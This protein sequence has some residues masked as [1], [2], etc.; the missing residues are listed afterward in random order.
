MPPATL[1]PA[2]VSPVRLEDRYLLAEGEVFLSGV[3]ALVR[4]LL[5]QHVADADAGRRTGIFASGYQGSPLG[6]FDRELA[7]LG[8]LAQRHDLVHRPGVNEE[9]GATAVWG[10]QLVGTL[11]NPL[12]DGVLGVWYGKA[13]GVDRATDAMRH[14]NYVGTDPRGGV[15]ALCGDDPES[16]S[17]TLP[18]ASEPLLAALHIPV[19]VPGSVQEVLDLGRHAIACS[20]A[21][22]LWTA[23]KIITVVADGAATAAVGA[24]RV[25]PVVPQLNW[26]GKPY[27]HQPSGHLLPPNSLEMERTLHGVRLEL[28]RRYARVNGLNRILADPPTARLGV[29][30]AGASYYDL[31]EAISHLGVGDRLRILK[32]GMVYPLDRE[33]VRDFAGGLD[34]I[35]VLEQKGPF[36]EPLVKDALY[37]SSHTP[38]VTGESDDRGRPLLATTGVLS[39]DAIARAIG[40]RLLV[41]EDLPFVQARLDQIDATARRPSVDVGQTRTPHF[42]SG[43]PH[44]ASTRAPEDS[45][46]GAGIGCHTM[47]MLTTAGRGHVVGTTQMGGEGAQWIGAAPF[48]APRH[49]LQN[50]GDGTFHHS[51]S[52]AIRA[53]IAAGVNVTYKILYNET[54]AMTGGQ[55]PTGQM[56][57]A[58]MARSLEAEGVKRIIIT[59][60]DVRRY[61]GVRLPALA[62]VRDRSTLAETQT[63]LAA[64]DGVTVLIH[65]QA[66]ANELR[67]ARRRGTAIDPPYR[68]LINERVCEGCGDCGAKSECL[69]LEPVDTEFGRKTRIDPTTCNKDLSCIDGDCPSF[70]RVIPPKVAKRGSPDRSSRGPGI[71]LPDPVACV[72]TDDVRIRLIGI[73]GTGVVTVSQVLGLAALIDGMHAVGLDQTGLSQKAGPV[74]SDVHLSRHPID[75]G[76]S[77][78]SGSSNVLLGLDIIGTATAQNLSAADPARTV[79]VVSTSVVPTVEMVIDVDAP[80]VDVAAAVGAINDATRAHDNVFLDSHSLAMAVFGDAMPANVIVL[81]AAWQCGAVPVS[82]D[83]I[84]QAFTLNGVAVERNLA[85]FEWGRAAVASPATVAAALEPPARRHELTNRER[86]LIDTVAPTEGELR[87]LLEIR[88]PDLLGWGGRTSAESYLRRLVAVRDLEAQRLPGSTVVTEAFAIGLHKLIAYKDEYEVARLHLEALAALPRGSKATILLHPPFLRALG[89]KRKLAFGSWFTPVLRVLKHAR[90]ARGTPLDLFGYSAVRRVERA[91]PGGYSALVVRG[92][93]AVEPASLDALIALT[94]LPDVVR[95]YE[96]LKLRNVERFRSEAEHLV[97]VL[98]SRP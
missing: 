52:L 61:E 90:R 13:P 33:A 48:L 34:E 76:V 36:L 98:E 23:L 75:G 41:R 86:D 71:E 28:A 53:A 95:G 85:A 20:R 63:E 92:L 44:S 40:A 2:H 83:A 51:G 39:P 29:V 4:L 6:G 35:I 21:S 7:G 80:A 46:V 64:L 3:Q 10:T 97:G 49:F 27:V 96:D 45:I 84:R 50:L 57:V 87:R 91:L 19:I 15:I 54:V 69:S 14:G 60:T 59:T 55:K 70:M 56:S 89:V 17:S 12:Y 32:L 68:V 62:E 22:G 82:R 5:D 65:D 16:K 26:E 38:V 77:L 24:R 9:L 79:A 42:C 31:L 37:G 93:Q 25:T 30:V 74:V 1:A 66:C 73:G 43:C 81:G 11:P 94:K 88:V 67:R 8:E 58:A 47:V 18:S 78:S 72:P